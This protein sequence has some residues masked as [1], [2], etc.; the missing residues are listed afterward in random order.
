MAA[1]AD[2]LA[3]RLRIEPAMGPEPTME[4]A[5]KLNIPLPK[6]ELLKV[7]RTEPWPAATPRPLLLVPKASW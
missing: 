4:V 3:E 1:G 7:A 6:A 2:G 5:E